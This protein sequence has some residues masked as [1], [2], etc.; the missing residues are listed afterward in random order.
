[1]SLVA[2]VAAHWQLDVRAPPQQL[3]GGFANLVLRVDTAREPV[4][5][6]VAPDDVDDASIEWEHALL[7]FLHAAIA[8]VPEPLQARDGSTWLVHDGRVVSL[9]PF[10]DGAHLDKRDPQMRSAAAALLAEIHRR[11]LDWP[12]R[13]EPRV[14]FPSVAEFDWEANVVYSWRD[15]VA[16]LGAS[17]ARPLRR[18]LDEL[19]EWVA[20]VPADAV[21]A[22]IHGDYY[23]RNV[24]VV[25]GRIRAVLDWDNARPEWLAWE[26]GRSTWEFAHEGAELPRAAAA[27]FLEAYLASGGPV[28]AAD[29]DLVMPSIRSVRLLEALSAYTEAARRREWDAEYTQQNLDALERLRDEPP[30]VRA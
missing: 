25:D 23:A 16:F 10:F 29:L 5:V 13:L 4:V 24:L 18:E 21:V 11:A 14:N 20:S 3:H 15:V 6:R 12:R 17:A 2:C 30:L 8:Q 27:A 22:P 28:P 26:L 9:T 19:R 1:M 7:R